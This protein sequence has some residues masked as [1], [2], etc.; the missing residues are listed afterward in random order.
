[1]PFAQRLKGP[2]GLPAQRK[3]IASALPNSSLQ[4]GAIMDS[5]LHGISLCEPS[6]HQGSSRVLYQRHLTLDHVVRPED[7][8]Q[9]EQFEALAHTV[10]DL[11]SQRWLLT[12]RTYQQ[13][14]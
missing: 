9:R 11:L 7:A 2:F 8:T 3:Q 6:Q 4:K 1:M 13:R 10:R 12:E 14:N 5:T